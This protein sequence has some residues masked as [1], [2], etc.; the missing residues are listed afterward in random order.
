MAA[1]VIEMAKLVSEQEEDFR[2]HKTSK[3]TYPSYKV[4][5]VDQCI[6]AV[7]DKVENDLVNYQL[8]SVAP[9]RMFK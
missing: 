1:L 4:M 9:T 2:K 6:T 8:H 7:G 3:I 5:N